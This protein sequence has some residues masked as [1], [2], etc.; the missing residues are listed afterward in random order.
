MVLKQLSTGLVGLLCLWFSSAAFAQVQQ[1]TLSTHPPTF[2]VNTE[3]TVTVADV[4]PSIWGVTDIY[5]WTWVER[6]EQDLGSPTNGTWESSNEAQRMTDNGDGTFSFTFVP[7]QLFGTG[8]ITEI[9]V[10]AKARNGSDSG[11]GEKKT[12]DVYFEV[13]GFQLVL[14]SPSV[15]SILVPSGTNIEVVAS[16][17]EEATFTLSSD[18]AIIDQTST[19]ATEYSYSLT[20][21]E[22]A[23]YTLVA[24]DG[25]ESDSENFQ[26][27]IEPNVEEAPLPEGLKDGINLNPG[28]PTRATLVFFAPGKEFVHVLGDFNGWQ[29]NDDY[30]MKK[31]S[32]RNRFWLEISG[33]NPGTDHLY[34]YLVE[35]L[36]NVADPYSTLV[37]D[38]FGNDEF[39]PTEVYPNLPEYPSGLASK[40]VTVLNTQEEEYAWEI[41]DFDKPKR[42]DLVVYELLIR[43]FDERHSFEAVIDRL[44]YLE[45]L[46][47]NALELMPVSEFDGNE[48][49]GYNP[50]FH[51][52]LDKYYGTK[53]AFKRLV[54]ECHKRGIAVF[55]DVVYNHGTGQHPYYQLWNTDNG[56]TGGQASEDNPFFNPTARH[57][58][59]V[60]NDFD[61][62]YSGTRD[63]VIR[64]VQY[65]I[66]EFKID[67][68][69]WDLTKGFTQNC[70]SNDE[71]CTNAT[72]PDRIEVLKQYADAQWAIDPDF[73]VIFEHLGG[74]DEEEQWADY[75]IDEG[76]GILL[77]NKQTDP[78]NEATMGYHENNQSNM[79]FAYHVFKGF[80]QPS[81]ISYMESHDEQ[82]LMFKNLEFGNVS[83]DYS[84][85]D[86]ET[87]LSRMETAGAFFFTIPGPK[88]L[89]QF[90]ELGYEVDINEPC[91]VCNK[92]IRWEYA[93]DPDR[94][95]I[96]NTWKKLIALK[97]E[98]PIFET[99]EIVFDLGESSGLKRIALSQPDV[100]EGEI[101][102]VVILGNFG[103]TAQTID[104]QL[105]RTGTWYEPLLNNRPRE[106]AEANN[107]IE[108]KPGAFILFSDA[109]SL[110]TVDPNDLDGDG[111]PN[112]NDLCPDTEIG[113][114]VDVDGCEVFSLPPSNFQILTQGS[115]CP[116]TDNAS[117]S[118]ATI[119][120][121]EYTVNLSNGQGV[122]IDDLFSGTQWFIESLEPGTY[123]LCLGVNGQADYLRCFE[124]VLTEP[125]P[126]GVSS[127]LDTE[128]GKLVLE[129]SGSTTYTIRHNQR[130]LET[131]TSSIELDLDEGRNFIEVRGEQECQGVYSEEFVLIDRLTAWPNPTVNL[132]RLQGD[133]S[134]EDQGT[135][136]V[137]GF[138]MSGRL[139]FHKEIPRNRHGQEIELDLSALRKGVYILKVG[140][141]HIRV[142]K[143]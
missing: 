10:L 7:S 4:N 92:P 1:G 97:I 60:F 40:A 52:A 29:V 58:Y 123:E 73:F 139:V 95:A 28:D 134:P 79:Q 117:I 82:R 57:A 141:Q 124:L 51:M 108:L 63:Y 59:S 98:E 20:A 115:S 103:L 55:L 94:I 105:P 11:S 36:I 8:D 111:V 101:S 26:V 33:L 24:T 91:R 17:S 13:G 49:W 39:I 128:E 118:V 53:N 12:Q 32:S 76:K 21:I 142:V 107:P 85:K 6:G 125:E 23:F 116:G 114:T 31:D 87:A 102:E 75:R 25:T 109:P 67:G 38:G 30:L 93:E 61:H 65:W 110:S 90:G 81:A 70:S 131:T 78:Y 48:S 100:S 121:L 3:I 19:P 15:D 56:G 122:D 137:R 35:A 129:L 127:R 47:I 106:I 66:E 77:W 54:D 22:T 96:Y 113:V 5:I 74:I 138:D 71:G 34:Q 120:S 143:R 89:W 130:V 50:S 136:E 37:L 27:I 16:T 133:Y 41:T 119:E 62:S 80:S 140:D 46:G 42:D 2:G 86:L 14:T 45:E 18:G 88:M 126:L 135:L 69:R 68:M 72:Q 132:L 83:G 104:P 84:V 112:A 99:S 64:T 43:D 44:D 9:G